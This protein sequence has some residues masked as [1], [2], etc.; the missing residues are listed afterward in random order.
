M[1]W[2]GYDPIEPPWW[3][4]YDTAATEAE[5]KK[6]MDSIIP[7]SYP[8]N[9]AG[10]S[11]TSSKSD[12][13]SSPAQQ[14]KKKGTKKVASRQKKKAKKYSAP[15]KKKY[16]PR[17]LMNPEELE[18]HRAKDRAKYRRRMEKKKELEQ[19]PASKK[20]RA[21]ALKPKKRQEE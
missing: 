7:N 10:D 12:V 1:S 16:V 3:L 11:A 15:K 9:R 19:L 17:H 5:W 18:R 21:K 4:A 2:H 13:T 20:S 8:A 14:V 6:V